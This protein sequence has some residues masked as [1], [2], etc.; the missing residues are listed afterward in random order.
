MYCLPFAGQMLINWMLSSLPSTT[1]NDRDAVNVLIL[2]CCTNLLVAGVIKQ[3]PDKC[4]PL[5]DAF[6][7]SLKQC[8]LYN[9]YTR[10]EMAY[11]V[12]DT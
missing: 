9:I 7:V 8:T 3:I 6:R 10:D 5:Q 1:I 11:R 12:N 4:A 2:Q